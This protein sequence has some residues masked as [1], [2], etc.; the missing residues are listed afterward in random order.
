MIDFSIIVPV[1]NRPEIIKETLPLML[2]QDYENYEVIAVDDGSTDNSLEVLNSIQHP[3][4]K[5]YS[6][7]NGERGA[8]RNYG[9]QKANGKYVNFFDCDDWMYPNHLSVAKKLI[10]E[11]SDP[12]VMHTSY[13][14]KDTNGNVLFAMLP[15]AIGTARKLI[16]TNFLACN[17]VFIRRDI[18]LKNPF[19]ESRKL[20]SAE[21]WEIWLRLA[22]RYKIVST[23]EV[24]FAIQ[25][26]EERSLNTISPEKIEARNLELNHL[27][28]Q[29]D[30]FKKFYHDKL[31]F[32]YAYSLTFIALNFANNN[33]TK[34][35]AKSYLAKAFKQHPPIIFTKRYLATLKNT[36]LK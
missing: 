32:F 24:T 31:D 17:P 18:F 20:S 21:D 29:D 30:A 9:A 27:L 35:K 12:E 10:D 15:P 4:L 2:S 11:N 26:H 14:H 34:E 33:H 5:V 22:S 23:N 8:A 16:Y 13:E 36:F 1:Y 19:N 7:T 25:E 6:K 3:K 28:S